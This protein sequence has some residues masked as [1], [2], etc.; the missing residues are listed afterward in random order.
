M[1]EN[2]MIEKGKH[3][4]MGTYSQ[5]PIVIEKGDGVFLT[6]NNGKQYL[7]MVSGIAVNSL[8]YNHPAVVKAIE[9]QAETLIH[10]SNLYWNIPQIELAEKLCNASGLDKAFFCNSGA[11][12][13]ESAIKLAR[14]YGK[15]RSTIISMVQSF[16]GRTLGALK[17][18]G[19]TK[20]QNGFAPLP[21]GF[22][23]TEANNIDM[24]D[25]MVDD[26]TCAI[27]LEVIQGEAGIIA[28]DEAYLKHVEAI[29]QE[30]DILFIIDEVQTGMGRTGYAF[31]HQ[32][33]N[34]HPDIVTMAKALAGGVPMGAMLAKDRVAAA[35]APGDHASTF[36]G[37]PLASHVACAVADIIFGADFLADVR[38][39]GAYFAERLA[40][41][42][43]GK[44]VL[45]V[46]GRGL[47]LGLLLSDDIQPSD[48]VGAAANEGLL[49]CTAGKQVLRFVP[50]LIITKE[51]IDQAVDCLKK[52][53]A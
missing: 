34:L 22:K 29:C 47:M 6:D 7:D 37:N 24:L 32:K 35:F 26:D 11:E 42:V 15:G 12:A 36:G 17:A 51:E 38:E 50:P 27:M 20:Y 23:Y 1:M 3:Y 43:D 25:A 13:N 2:N 4:I 44:R 16:H 41:L 39:K 48:I 21:E 5:A 10:V 30:K 45:E 8:G 28:L 19:Q 31:A 40:E 49:I 14:K 53:L 46:R 18:T 9:E 52:V 33:Y